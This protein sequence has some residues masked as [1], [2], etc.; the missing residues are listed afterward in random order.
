LTK[1]SKWRLSQKKGTSGIRLMWAEFPPVIILPVCRVRRNPES[2]RPMDCNPAVM[3]L[4]F[5]SIEKKV[6]NFMLPKR[7]FWKIEPC[8]VDGRR[9]PVRRLDPWPEK[10]PRDA[11]ERRH[12][13][14]LQAGRRA[15]TRAAPA[16]RVRR[17]PQRH[18]ALDAVA[19]RRQERRVA[20]RWRGR[21]GPTAARPPA[22]GAPARAPVDLD[23]Q[24]QAVASPRRTHRRHGVR[25]VLPRLLPRQQPARPLDVVLRARSGVREPCDESASHVLLCG[26]CGHC[27]PLVGVPLWRIDA[28]PPPSRSAGHRR[29]SVRCIGL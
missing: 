16:D 18:L 14:G 5:L 4:F 17:L 2:C 3:V 1:C 9:S 12:V 7:R 28:P 23:L 22:D 10:G 29:V 15:A 26:G 27:V 13:V 25:L 6:S 19:H 20:R 21:L 24:V 8:T 11:D